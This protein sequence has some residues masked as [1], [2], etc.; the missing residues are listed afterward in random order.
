MEAQFL[1]FRDKKENYE[2]RISYLMDQSKAQKEQL[3]SNF[4][5]LK[6]LELENTVLKEDNISLQE[7]VKSY[8]AEI[9]ELRTVKDTHENQ[10]ENLSRDNQDLH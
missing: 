6:N 10:I 1:E 2:A 7:N 3:E 8:S 4:E 9:N 5:Q